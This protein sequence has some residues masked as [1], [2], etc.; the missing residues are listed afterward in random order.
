MEDRFPPLPPHLA[1]LDR[2]VLFDGECN[3][4]NG[5]AKFLIP[6]DPAGRLRLAAVQSQT[7]QAILAFAGLPT[8][9]F[10]TMVFLEGGRAYQKS[11]AFLRI[12][13]HLRRPWRLARLGVAVPRPARDW[14]YD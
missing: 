7:G 11:D 12:V 10:D 2:V 13:R 3:L 4:C 5:W 8:D 14:L 1:G 6:R 9:R